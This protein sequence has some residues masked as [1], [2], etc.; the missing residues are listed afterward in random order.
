MRNKKKKEERKKALRTALNDKGSGA[1]ADLG[2]R[3]AHAVELGKTLRVGATQWLGRGADGD[4]KASGNLAGR[5]S[6][7]VINQYQP[8]QQLLRTA[9]AAATAAAGTDWTLRGTSSGRLRLA[10]GTEKDSVN[11]GWTTSDAALASTLK[12]A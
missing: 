8:Q 2:G 7:S 3:E 1:A 5:L 10:D 12:R 9:A 11:G 6:Q 4:R